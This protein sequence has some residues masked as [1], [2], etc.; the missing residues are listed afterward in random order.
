MRAFIGLPVPEPW[1]APL[2]RAQGAVPGGRKVDVDDLHLTLAFL[3][4]Q[5]TEVLG[6]LH[7]TLDARALPAVPLRPAAFALLGAVRPRAVVLDLAPDPALSALRDTVRRAATNAGI[8]LP[9]ERFRPHIT[10]LRFSTSAPPDTGRL[11]AAL[12]RLG[13]PDL[14]PQTASGVTLWSSLLT[15]DGPIYETLASYRSSA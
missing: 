2:V 12:A 4:D 13:A 7:D 14:P 3:D 5:P 1:I 15:P 11:P 6:A 8:T 10:L 9:R